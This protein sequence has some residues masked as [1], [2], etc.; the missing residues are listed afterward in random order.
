LKAVL[1][2]IGID[3]GLGGIHGPLFEDGTYD[4]IPIPDNKGIDSRTYSNQSGLKR[5]KLIK[6]FPESKQEKMKNKS[7]HFDP[8][9]KTFTYGDP[10]RLKAR[11]RHLEPG[12]L[13]LFYCGL[14]GYDHK[15]EPALY[16]IG[17]FEIERAGMANTFSKTELQSL[18]GKNYHVMHKEVYKKQKNELVLVKGN[19]NSRLLKKAVKISTYSQDKS[20]KPLKVLSKKF[21]KTFGDF[22]GKISIQRSSPRWIAD[23]YLDAT[24]NFVKS[25]K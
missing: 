15:S 5:K 18:F 11:L 13:L 17:Y 9:F 7:I 20:G 19:R 25:L 8:E 16:L 3:T 14:Q 21:Q 10:T 23:D 12:D 22:N 24:M 4:Y 2:R 1:L 6:Y